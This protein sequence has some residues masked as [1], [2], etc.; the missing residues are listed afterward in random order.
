MFL[1]DG[2]SGTA[3]SNPVV[4][5]ML[6]EGTLIAVRERSRS[7]RPGRRFDPDPERLTR[8]PLIVSATVSRAAVFAGHPELRAIGLIGADCWRC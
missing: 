2:A 5:L 4:R 8:Y 7:R 3:A 1:P 6:N